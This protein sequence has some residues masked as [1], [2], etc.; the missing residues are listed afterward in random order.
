[1]GRYRLKDG[2]VISCQTAPNFC[3]AG[4]VS[5]TLSVFSP[6]EMKHVYFSLV[7]T[8]AITQE[9]GSKIHNPGCSIFVSS[10]INLVKHL[11]WPRF[12]L[13]FFLKISMKRAPGS[14]ARTTSYEGFIKCL[15]KR[16]ADQHGLNERRISSFMPCGLLKEKPITAWLAAITFY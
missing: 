16:C 12:F 3:V 9:A 14:R 10:L 2:L 13:L 8:K 4:T 11:R 6:R 1:M 7:Q 5:S 15:Y